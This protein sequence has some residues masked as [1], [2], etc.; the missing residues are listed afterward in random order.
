[1]KK[2]FFIIIEDHEQVGP[3]DLDYLAYLYQKGQLT[4]DALVWADGMSDWIRAGDCPDL[5]SIFCKANE[6]E[7]YNDDGLNEK[8]NFKTPAIIAGGIIVAALLL[9]FVFAK[10]VKTSDFSLIPVSNDGERWGYINR[11][12]VFV[13]N[14]QFEEADFFS[15]GLAKIRASG[16]KVGYINK[17]GEYVIPAIYKGGTAFDGGLAFVVHEG[18]FLTCIDKRGDTKFV[19]NLDRAQY[20]SAFSDGL[21]LF[22]TEKG[23][24]G[25]VDKT[26]TTVINAQFQM[27]LPFEGGFARVWHENVAGFIDKNGR[28]VINP[29][30]TSVGNFNEGN[31]A[32]SDGNNKWGYINTKG[33]YVINPQFDDA[34]IFSSK[35]AAVR[36]GRTYGYINKDGRL[37]INPQFDAASIFS[38]GL[39]AVRSGNK[40]GYIKKDGKYEINT[41]FDFAGDFYKGAALVLNANKW[42]IINKKGQYIANP[43]YNHAKIASS[44]DTA[45]FFLE[46][47]YYDT[48][49]FIRLF[50]SR[51]SGNSFDGVRATTTLVELSEHAVYAENLNTREENRAEYSRPIAITNDISIRNVAFVFATTPIF[52]W[53]NNEWGR[54]IRQVYD[55]A[56]P[57]AAVYQF[58]LNGKAW[59][60]RSVVFSAL[61]AEIERRQGQAMINLNVDRREVFYLFQ[62]GGK[63]NF[64]IVYQGDAITLYVGFNAQYLRREFGI[65]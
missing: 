42:G 52:S 5:Y 39:A 32:F 10:I 2:E 9:F 30:F 23:E 14:P 40:F 53:L 27:A 24:H 35:L 17:K 47:D 22:I 50:F 1:M 51:E 36:Q 57:D 60:K 37:I 3:Y 56:T 65:L 43:Q 62:D 54:R 26:G 29:Q 8:K 44:S 4:S 21:A 46:S 33:S 64:V 28:I 18:G 16:G 63:L 59:E 15:D 55:N 31:A 11:K 48:S 49:E 6:D 13:I 61:R 38:E 25:F 12:G 41:Q 58:A 34:G 7:D 45:P 20:V 19:L